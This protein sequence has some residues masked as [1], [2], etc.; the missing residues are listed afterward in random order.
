MLTL[1]SLVHIAKYLSKEENEK[2]TVETLVA[3]G[4]EKSWKVR[5]CIAK[6]FSDF[7][8]AYGPELTNSHLIQT[9]NMLLCD[10][11]SEVR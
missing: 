8:E 10:N 9:F 3:A 1:E 7:T 2:Y 11:E 6:N 4:E 5:L